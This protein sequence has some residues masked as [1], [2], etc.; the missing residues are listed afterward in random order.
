MFRGALSKMLEHFISPHKKSIRFI[1]SN[2]SEKKN[3][4]SKNISF[5]DQGLC[6]YS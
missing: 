4:S 2:A 5:F 3:L 6:N 1:S